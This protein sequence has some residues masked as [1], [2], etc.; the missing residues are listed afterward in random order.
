[1]KLREFVAMLDDKWLWC[2]IA[3]YLKS[4]ANEHIVHECT[5]N[6]DF[7]ALVKEFGDTELFSFYS[8]ILDGYV[9][10]DFIFTSKDGRLVNLSTGDPNS[11][12]ASVLGVKYVDP[13]KLPEEVLAM[14][15]VRLL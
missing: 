12:K 15:T 13:K 9:F 4:N 14:I 7:E 2:F 11:E 5:R 3:D 8:D 6:Q 10:A 1:M